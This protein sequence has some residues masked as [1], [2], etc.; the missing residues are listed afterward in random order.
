MKILI[1]AACITIIAGGA[2][3]GI[4]QYDAYRAE[5]AEESLRQQQA[6][7]LRELQD[8]QRCEDL[9]ANWT[10]A[11]RDELLDCNRRGILKYQ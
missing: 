5:K 4:T 9:K 10:E 11:E 8:R 2:Y 3:F 6:Q 1:A 7:T